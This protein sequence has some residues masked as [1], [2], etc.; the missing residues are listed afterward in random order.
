M[1]RSSTPRE[2]VGATSNGRTVRA[3]SSRRTSF[4][5]EVRPFSAL[6]VAEFSQA[7]RFVSLMSRRCESRPAQTVRRGHTVVKID[8]GGRSHRSAEI[9][10]NTARNSRLPPTAADFR[11]IQ[12]GPPSTRCGPSTA[13]QNGFG[14]R[15]AVC[16]GRSCPI[17]HLRRRRPQGMVEAPAL[18]ARPG[19]K[20]LGDRG[21]YL[22]AGANR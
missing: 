12:D 10:V 1:A 3:V 8:A 4:C 2:F 22:A 6:Q 20:L 16:G 14:Y 15:C 5:G 11:T 19:F 17:V 18:Q 9:A 13:F 7:W 21:R